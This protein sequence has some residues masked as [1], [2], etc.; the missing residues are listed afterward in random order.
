MADISIIEWGVYG[1]IAYSSL[2][3]LIISVVKNMPD[4]KSQSILRSMWIIPGIICA[5][6]LMMSGPDITLQSNGVE[7]L[8]VY[9]GT[10]GLL[11][12]NTTIIQNTPDYITIQDPIWGS[13][14]LMIFLVLILYVI[15][16]FMTLLTKT[17]YSKL[18]SNILSRF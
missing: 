7:F 16:Q 11:L 6:L 12:T 17:K 4:T 3:M 10:S 18:L 8:E 14:H 1:F 15:I 2:L 13:V 9:N 5:G